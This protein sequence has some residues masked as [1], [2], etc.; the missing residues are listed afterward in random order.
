MQVLPWFRKYYPKS[1]NEVSGQNE[2][3]DAAKKFISNYKPGGK[4]LLLFGPPGVGK[5]CLV[6]ALANELNLELMEV[7]ASDVRTKESL[8]S[9][10]GSS[11]LQA[12][13]FGRSK[14]ILIDELDG[15]SGGDR[16]GVQELARLIE[17]SKFPIIITANDP[18]DYK[19]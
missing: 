16:G 14:L 2:A 17:S 3:V 13:L 10:V 9:I 7:N 4:A 18:Y 1:L 15:L 11:S 5:T 8:N 6:Y 12:S 19:F